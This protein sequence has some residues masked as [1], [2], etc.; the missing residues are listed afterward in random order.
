MDNPLDTFLA[1]AG[2][3]CGEEEDDM[4]GDDPFATDFSREDNRLPPGGG[5]GI[6]ELGGTFGSLSSPEDFGREPQTKD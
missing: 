4:D 6:D 2:E 5:A 1:E 3:D